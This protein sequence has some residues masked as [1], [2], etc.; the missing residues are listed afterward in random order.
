MP[1]KAARAPRGRERALLRTIAR[2][3]AEMAGALDDVGELLIV[4]DMLGQGMNTVEEH[5]GK[6]LLALSAAIS[7][8]FCSACEAFNRLLGPWRNR[9]LSRAPS[10][11]LRGPYAVAT[12]PPT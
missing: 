10:T 9:D 12:D 11:A 2:L 4:L 8:R 5:S 6:P 1:G 3:D 7:E